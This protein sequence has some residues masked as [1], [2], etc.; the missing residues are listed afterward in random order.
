MKRLGQQN[1]LRH[2]VRIEW[3]EAPQLRNHFRS[4]S[5]RLVILRPA[6]NHAVPNRGQCAP[7]AAPLDPI[8][9]SAHR[10]CVIRCRH[11][12]RKVVRLIRAFHPEGCLR[13]S[14]P[15]N[16]ALQN[17]SQRVTSIEDREFDTRRAAIDRQ[18][19]WISWLHG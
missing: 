6:M 19:A 7:P 3:T 2:M 15:L 4:D 16:P 14:N 13:Q 9:Q 18:N 10:H 17:P 5:L 8:H 12:S 1:L 11:E